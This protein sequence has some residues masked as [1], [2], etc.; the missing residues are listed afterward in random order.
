VV[1][2]PTVNVS[3]KSP[4]IPSIPS[5]IQS[6]T[7]LQ[8]WN[9]PPSPAGKS[10]LPIPSFADGSPVFQLGSSQPSSL[11]SRAFALHLHTVP[12]MQPKP[13][14]IPQSSRPQKRHSRSPLLT[15]QGPRIPPVQDLWE[16][17]GS[18]SG[19]RASGSRAPL[20]SEA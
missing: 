12:L 5:H 1:R 9:P 4:Q 14:S 6:Q 7:P 15:T 13:A 17:V 3:W 10:P 18:S 16:S 20:P 19:C 8:N 2:R 11:A